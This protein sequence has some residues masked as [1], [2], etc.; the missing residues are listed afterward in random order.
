MKQI[1]CYEQY[2]IWELRDWAN[3]DFDNQVKIPTTFPAS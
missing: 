1:E 3:S 2:F